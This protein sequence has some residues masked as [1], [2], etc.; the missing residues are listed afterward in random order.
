MNFKKISFALLYLLSGF[1][2]HSHSA[3]AIE[4][5][6]PVTI[7]AID[8][9]YDGQDIIVTG[10]TLTIDGSHSFNSIVLQNSATLTHSTASTN[11]LEITTQSFAIDA[12]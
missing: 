1:F 5:T 8:Q 6:T 10:T 4:F 9:S 7:S 2:L 3:F 11:R 12:S